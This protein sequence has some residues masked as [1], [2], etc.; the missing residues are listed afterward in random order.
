MVWDVLCKTFYINTA[1]VLFSLQYVHWLVNGF[2]FTADDYLVDE[3]NNTF[4]T[5]KV[6]PCKIAKLGRY[7]YP[8]IV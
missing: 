6:K 2:H 3:T 7:K 4:D 8:K 1:F 5:L